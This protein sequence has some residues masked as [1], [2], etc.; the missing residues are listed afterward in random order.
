MIII[1]EGDSVIESDTVGD[2]EAAIG[3]SFYV[4][5]QSSI[6][7]VANFIIN[8][9]DAVE[10]RTVWYYHSSVDGIRT[11]IEDRLVFLPDGTIGRMI[12]NAPWSGNDSY[13]IIL[14][15][16]LRSEILNI[17]SLFPVHEGFFTF[18][19]SSIIF[20]LNLISQLKS[21]SSD[22]TLYGNGGI[23]IC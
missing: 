1:I 14:R 8:T 4:R 6:R 17:P 11:E 15:A 12:T 2:F 20:T 21:V 13:S 10:P 18:E 5:E 9:T 22:M 7:I 19:V 3:S 16:G 23:L